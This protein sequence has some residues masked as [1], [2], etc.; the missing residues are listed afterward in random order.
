MHALIDMVQFSWPHIAMFLVRFEVLMVAT[1]KT[2][3]R[4]QN[5]TVWYRREKNRIVFGFEP[6]LARCT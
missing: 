4:M 6:F 5:Q 3:S 1:I 2:A